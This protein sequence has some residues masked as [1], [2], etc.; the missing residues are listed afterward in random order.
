DK[1][2]LDE[3]LGDDLGG[4]LSLGLRAGEDKIRVMSGKLVTKYLTPLGTFYGEMPFAG[5]YLWK[6][7]G[8][9]V[10]DQNEFVH[11]LGGCLISCRAA[12]LAATCGSR[13]SNCPTYEAGKK[14]YVLLGQPSLLSNAEA[15]LASGIQ[16]T[17]AGI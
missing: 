8:K 3:L 11:G 6:Y 15:R 2:R 5:W 12:I 17:S 16:R 10:F 9:G 13:F 1:Q 7:F 4:L 14:F